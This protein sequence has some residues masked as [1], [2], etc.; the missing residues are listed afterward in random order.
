MSRRALFAETDNLIL[1]FTGKCQGLR[2]AKKILKKDKAG[3]LT[4]PDFKI[5]YKATAIKRVWY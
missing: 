2:I 5:Y 1:K 4:L 3:G